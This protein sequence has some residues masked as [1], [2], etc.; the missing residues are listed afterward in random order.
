M[1]AAGTFEALVDYYQTTRRYNPE[2]YKTESSEL[3]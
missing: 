2:C 3:V 1:E